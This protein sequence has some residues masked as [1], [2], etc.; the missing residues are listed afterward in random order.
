MKIGG[1]LRF[2]LIDYP[3]KICAIIFTQGCNYRCVYCHN[4]ELV[5]PSLFLPPIPEEEIFTF[6]ERRRGR[7]EAVE[8]TGGEPTLQPDL[9]KVLERIKA[10]GYLIKLDSNGS[11]PEMLEKAISLHLLDYVA[12]DVKA[13]LE[14]YSYVANCEVDLSAIQKSIYIVMHSGLEYEF[15]TTVLPS[16]L[17]PEDILNIGNL[18]KGAKLYVLQRF[19]STKVLNLPSGAGEGYSESELRALKQR[20]EENYVKEC[21]LR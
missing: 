8:I 21:I 10:M 6:L 16:Q 4:P 11:H 14:K 13:P 1:F 7:L 18:L 9:L 17:T 2:S 15:R 12:M 3:G 20:L 19:S 5:H